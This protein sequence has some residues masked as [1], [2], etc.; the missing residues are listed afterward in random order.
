MT[1]LQVTLLLAGFRPRPGMTRN[2]S[3]EV[4]EGLKDGWDEE[5]RDMRLE[6]LVLPWNYTRATQ[7]V[8]DALSETRPELFLLLDVDPTSSDHIL[9][10]LAANWTDDPAPDQDGAVVHDTIIDR[11]G[12]VAYRSKLPLDGI[13]DKL[14]VERVPCRM[15]HKAGWGVFNHVYYQAMRT[16]AQDDLHTRGGAMQLPPLPGQEEGEETEGRP[17]ER[18]LDEVDMVLQTIRHLYARVEHETADT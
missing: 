7:L 14:L 13:W 9:Q 10:V 18:Q 17:I 16:I 2:P 3:L 11:E 12:P 6:P 4:I 1:E 8:R 5:E 15:G